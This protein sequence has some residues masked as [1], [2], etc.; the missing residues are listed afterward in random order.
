VTRAYVLKRLGEALPAGIALL[1]TVDDSDERFAR[2]LAKL[3]HHGLL[4]RLNYRCGVQLLDNRWAESSMSGFE[5]IPG[6][7]LTIQFSVLFAKVDPALAGFGFFNSVEVS[8][9]LP[10]CLFP[11]VVD[12]DVDEP[13]VSVG[14]LLVRVFR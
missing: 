14:V 12:L 13:P 8:V 2:M 5:P 6:V 3:I 11:E 1:A 7:D 9:E 10:S 4:L